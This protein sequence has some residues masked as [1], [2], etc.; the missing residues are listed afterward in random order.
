LEGWPGRNVGVAWV[1][2]GTLAFCRPSKGNS[3]TIGGHLGYSKLDIVVIGKGD[4]FAS[5]ERIVVG[6][7]PLE[8]I[9]EIG[10][11]V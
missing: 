3:R 7:R 10:S 4:V 1:D 9:V 5:V 8:V 2:S 6:I 11:F